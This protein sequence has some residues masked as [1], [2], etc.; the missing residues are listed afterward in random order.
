MVIPLHFLSSKQRCFPLAKHD[1]SCPSLEG[2]AASFSIV[3]N[4][5]P[6]QYVLRSEAQEQKLAFLSCKTTNAHTEFLLN[7]LRP[8]FFPVELAPPL[9]SFSLSLAKMIGERWRFRELLPCNQ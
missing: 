1:E 5:E 2:L 3:V 4:L 9:L 8:R 6:V 7:S